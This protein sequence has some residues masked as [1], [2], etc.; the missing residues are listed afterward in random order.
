MVWLVQNCR[1]NKCT[2]MYF[3]KPPELRGSVLEPLVDLKRSPYPSP[4]RAPLIPNPGSAPGY[5]FNRTLQ[6]LNNVIIIKTEVGRFKLSWFSRS[7][8]LFGFQIFWRWSYLLKVISET[9][10]GTKLDTYA[11]I[12]VCK[13]HY[14]AI[15]WCTKWLWNI[16]VS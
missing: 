5:V 7:H 4:S 13:V 1:S 8:G 9:Y 15:V 12:S 10:W 11:F 2:C 14:H 6:F 3:L 16:N